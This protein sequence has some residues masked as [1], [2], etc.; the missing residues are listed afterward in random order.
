MLILFTPKSRINMQ[1]SAQL[2]HAPLR[3][4]ANPLYFQGIQRCAGS[5]RTYPPASDRLVIS[6]SEDCSK[7]A[8]PLLFTLPFALT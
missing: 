3:R 6:C 8:L 2:E 4:T 7:G 5:R 1:K